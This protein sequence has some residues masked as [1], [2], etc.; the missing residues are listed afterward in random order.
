MFWK[1]IKVYGEGGAGDC[2]RTGHDEGDY[3]HEK[4][5]QVAAARFP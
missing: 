1:I 4:E 3:N 2:D 5:K